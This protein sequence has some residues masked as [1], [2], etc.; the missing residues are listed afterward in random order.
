MQG[1]EENKANGRMKG[2]NDRLAGRATKYGSLAQLG[3]NENRPIS[4]CRGTVER[5]FRKNYVVCRIQRKN[6]TK[7]IVQPDRLAPYQRTICMALRS[8]QPG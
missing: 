4:I 3:V 7:M 8:N 6:G 5:V 2:D 1:D